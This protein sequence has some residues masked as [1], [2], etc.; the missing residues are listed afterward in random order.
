DLRD[1]RLIYAEGICAVVDLAL[2]EAPVVLPREL[3]YFRLPLV[4]GAGNTAWVLETA[5]T[6]TAQLLRAGIPTL[7]YCSN[8]M[9]RS[10]TIAAAAIAKVRGCSL[11]EAIAII[12]PSGGVD[13]SPGLWT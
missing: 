1:L 12:L 10:P 13:V 4:D 7:V 3:A 2:E 8:G 5:V 11:S 9:S 6:T